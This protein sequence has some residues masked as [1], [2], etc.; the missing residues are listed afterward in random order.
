MIEDLSVDH[1]LAAH[2]KA[3]ADEENKGKN[4]D[5]NSFVNSAMERDDS[6]PN[7]YEEE[8]T[9]EQGHHVKKKVTKGPGWQSV[10]IESDGPMDMSN[11]GG[12]IGQMM[13]Q[14]MT[15]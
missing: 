1:D 4:T 11:I 10:E 3:E 15:Q 5:L 13:Q 8:M 7:E 12:I 6:K 2:E 9:D 14:Q